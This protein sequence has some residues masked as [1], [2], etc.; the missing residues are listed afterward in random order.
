MNKIEVIKTIKQVGAEFSRIRAALNSRD[1]TCG[2]NT[3]IGDMAK[4]FEQSTLDPDYEAEREAL[5]SY[6]EQLEAKNEELE[7]EVCE[8]HATIQKLLSHVNIAEVLGVNTK[9]RDE[10]K[11][12][13]V[14]FF[15]FK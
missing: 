2:Y 11:E 12:R 6:I 14:A 1:F 3:A 5:L 15:A 9:K 8:K 4:M 10:P 7:Q 13:R